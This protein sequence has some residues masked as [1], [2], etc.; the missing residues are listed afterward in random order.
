MHE[1]VHEQRL[2]GL[3]AVREL[4]GDAPLS[5]E[6]TPFLNIPRY[7]SDGGLQHRFEL[8]PR[9]FC[10]DTCTDG[11]R[12]RVVARMNAYQKAVLFFRWKG[13]DLLAER[14]DIFMVLKYLKETNAQNDLRCRWRDRRRPGTTGPY[15]PLRSARTPT[16]ERRVRRIRNC[17]NGNN[18]HSGGRVGEMYVQVYTRTC[19]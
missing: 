15:T 16:S 13:E 1:H 6:N 8:T 2:H 5:G 14:V 17:V 3:N 19:G 11:L 7:L 4:G 12:D 9:S 18:K 10:D